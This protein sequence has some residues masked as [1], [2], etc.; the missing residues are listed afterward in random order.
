MKIRYLVAGTLIAAGL[1]A[2][3]KQPAGAPASDRTA[4]DAGQDPGQAAALPADPGALP[5]IASDAAVALA[6]ASLAMNAPAEGQCALDAINGIPRQPQMNMSVGGAVMVGGWVADGEGNVPSRPAFV[7]RSEGGS[8]K[9]EFTA[10]GERQDVAEALDKPG[11]AAS[12]FNLTVS[13]EGV[14]AGTYRLGIQL[15][16]GRA[17]L[18]DFGVDLVIR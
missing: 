8:Y 11:L 6:S 15:D 17:S 3:S 2:C 5:P 18:C 14:P 12:G 1:V 13:T 16:P 4:A 7:M 9:A 10:G